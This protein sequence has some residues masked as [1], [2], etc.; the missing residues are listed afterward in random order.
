MSDQ[1]SDSPTADQVTAYIVATYPDTDVISA[2]GAT[3]FSCDAETHWPN[4]ATIVTTD[5]HDEGHPS[6]LDARSG[7]YRLNIGVG[8]K[9]FQSLVGGMADPEYAAL[10]RILPHPTYARQHWICI[11]SPTRHTFDSTVK[12]LLAE[13]HARV[14]KSATKPTA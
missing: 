10:D 9:T 8:T 12:P 7:L 1:Q 6:N 5:E 2:M 3:F 13:A 14:A 11:V 4:F